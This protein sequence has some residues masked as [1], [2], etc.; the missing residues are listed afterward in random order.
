MKNIGDV[1]TIQTLIEEL[2]RLVTER[3]LPCDTQVVIFLETNINTAD[4]PRDPDEM[5]IQGDW[6]EIETVGHGDMDGETRVVLT[7]HV[8]GTMIA[9]SMN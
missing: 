6:V 7:S 5:F 2:E 9:G 3:E 8:A 4:N 1:M